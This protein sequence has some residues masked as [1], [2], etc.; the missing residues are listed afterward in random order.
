MDGG[1]ESYGRIFQTENSHSKMIND[2]L[3]SGFRSKRKMQPRI[4]HIVYR[5]MKRAGVSLNLISTGWV[6]YGY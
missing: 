5:A 3:F 2:P 6:K 4:E 1:D